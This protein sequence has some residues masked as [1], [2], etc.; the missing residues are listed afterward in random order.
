MNIRKR[1]RP[2]QG[3]TQGAARCMW[4]EGVSCQK[5]KSS[6][7]LARLFEVSLPSCEGDDGSQDTSDDDIQLKQAIAAALGVS[8]IAIEH[9]DQAAYVPIRSDNREQQGLLSEE[10]PLTAEEALAD[11]ANQLE[12]ERQLAARQSLS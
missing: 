6:G 1:G 7:P 9:A 5:F 4:R 12:F 3:D 11:T 2:H 10:A 8:G